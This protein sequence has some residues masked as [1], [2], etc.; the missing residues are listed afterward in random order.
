MDTNN[1]PSVEQ[2]AL[3]SFRASGEGKP[4]HGSGIKFQRL[5]D[6]GA[7]RNYSE[8][9]ALGHV[10]RPR[11]SQTM[12]LAN[13]IPSIQEALLFLPRSVLRK[14]AVHICSFSGQLPTKLRACQEKTRV[15]RWA[16]S[17]ISMRSN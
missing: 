7:V 10:T 14:P 6:E 1:V 11:L 13:L 3:D 9:A 12:M 15:P 2:L 8:L 4:A 17:G 5:I 16:R